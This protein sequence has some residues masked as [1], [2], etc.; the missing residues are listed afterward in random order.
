[1]AQRTITTLVDDIDGSEATSTVSFALDGT[2]YEIDLNENHAEDLREVL[3]PFIS[4]ARKVSGLPSGRRRRA[5][6]PGGPAQS[7]AEIDP[8]EV[9]AWA[10]ANGIA[11]NARGRLRAG[12]IQEYQAAGH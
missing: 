10:E 8:K 6:R 9:R 7:T 11:V 3:A 4:V 12:V 5:A 2:A 1:M